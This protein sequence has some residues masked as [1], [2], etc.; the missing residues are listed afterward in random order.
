MASVPKYS[1]TKLGYLIRSM[2]NTGD[3]QEQLEIAEE[4]N[5]RFVLEDE[6]RKE[7]VAHDLE[8]YEQAKRGK[9]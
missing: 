7:Q 6:A 9:R 4:I 5:E 2:I 8:E 1:Q 3:K